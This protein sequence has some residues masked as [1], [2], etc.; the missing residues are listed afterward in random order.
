MSLRIMTSAIRLAL[1]TPVAYFRDGNTRRDFNRKGSHFNSIKN[2]RQSFI[3]PQE[4]LEDE[5]YGE[6]PKHDAPTELSHYK[7]SDQTVKTLEWKGIKSL[8]PIQAA[9]F[10]AITEGR[11]IIGKDRT[12]TGKTLAYALPVLEK[13]RERKMFNRTKGQLPYKIVLVPTRELA[14]QVGNEYKTL[15]NE[16]GEFHVTKVFGGASITF[17]QR[18]LMRGSEV[19]VGTPGRVKD[20]IER[21][22]LNLSELRAMV[23]DETDTMLD[24]GFQRDIETILKLIQSQMEEKGRKVTE[25]QFLLF[26]A[27]IPKFVLETSRKFMAEGYRFIDMIGNQPIKTSVTV[28]HIAIPY[29]HEYQKWNIL[30]RIMK[31]YASNNEKTI[32]FTETKAD[33]FSLQNM[34]P[35]NVK[36]SVLNGDIPQEERS[37][38]MTLFR[39]DKIDSIVTTNVLARGIDF[40]GV[41]LII[42]ASVPNDVESYIH[43]SGRTGR[44]GKKGISIIM[45][46]ERDRD[47]LRKIEKKAF[48]RFEHLNA[49]D[50][51]GIEE[52]AEVVKDE[53]PRESWKAVSPQ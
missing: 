30:K 45:Y 41:D 23:L 28:Q 5:V 25:I 26:S 44:A 6:K 16:P 14:V 42:Q 32:I 21:G 27:T 9:C 24:M 10:E 8:F 13:L 47:S 4:E 22:I 12:G 49:K 7:L 1:R 39:R 31:T 36:S 2:S 40:K 29:P 20:L 46:N 33:C 43:R 38:I 34:L 51:S 50:L 52:P 53:V 3:S 18:E 37:R 19:V 35:Q 48:I 11:D 17:Q 15:I